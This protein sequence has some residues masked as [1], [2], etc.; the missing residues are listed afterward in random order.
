MLIFVVKSGKFEQASQGN[1]ELTIHGSVQ[2]N[3]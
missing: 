3:K 1:D 2:K